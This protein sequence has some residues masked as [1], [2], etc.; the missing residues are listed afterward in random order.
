MENAPDIIQGSGKQIFDRP[1]LREYV[2]NPR[3]ND[4]NFILGS[5]G[6]VNR[7]LDVMN[8]HAITS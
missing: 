4:K 2:M 3:M 5:A 1:K 8:L 6:Q 7:V